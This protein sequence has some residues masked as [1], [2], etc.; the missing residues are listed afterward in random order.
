M[1][2]RKGEAVFL[3]YFEQDGKNKYEVIL[4]VRDDE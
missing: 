4:L 3:E 2:E 1:H